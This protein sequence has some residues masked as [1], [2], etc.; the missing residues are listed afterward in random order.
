MSSMYYFEQA[1]VV[2]NRW[3]PVMTKDKPVL[4]E[5]TS[6]IARKEGTGPRIRNVRA[7]PSFLQHLTLAQLYECFAP[8]GKFQNNYKDDYHV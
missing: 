6:R 7:I 4:K 2:G 1:A 5:G 8:G 3:C